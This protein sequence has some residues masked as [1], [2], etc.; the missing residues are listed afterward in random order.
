MLDADNRVL[1]G[2][3]PWAIAFALLVPLIASR[4]QVS[5]RV[6]SPQSSPY[7]REFGYVTLNDGVR[8]AYVAY[9]PS[10]DGKYP[11]IMQYDPY[12][13]AGSSSI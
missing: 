7:Y 4:S 6:A 5:A 3:I 8:L 11:T 2:R 10:R 9:R 13:A 12:V 1:N